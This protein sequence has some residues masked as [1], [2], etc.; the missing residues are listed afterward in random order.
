MTNSEWREGIMAA[1]DNVREDTSVLH[2]SAHCMSDEIV[3]AD[4]ET[5][6][7]TIQALMDAM[8]AN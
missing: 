5:L 3:R 6:R 2:S 1:C 7:E 4:M 8:E